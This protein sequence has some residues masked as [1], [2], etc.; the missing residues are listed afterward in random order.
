MQVM[1]ERRWVLLAVFCSGVLLWGEVRPALADAPTADAD[2]SADQQHVEDNAWRHLKS[3]ADHLRSAGRKELAENL[4]AEAEKLRLQQ[5]LAKKLTEL[6]ALREDVER[7]QA[8][9]GIGQVVTLRMQVVEC[10]LNDD[11]T[12]GQE[13]LKRLRNGRTNAAG[14]NDDVPYCCLDSSAEFA[15]VLDELKEHGSAKVLAEPHLATLSGRPAS[16]HTGGLQP[17][18]VP[19]SRGNSA[20]EFCEMGTR[21]DAVPTVHPDGT[22]HLKL[23]LRV[24]ETDAQKK[25][26]IGE[27]SIPQMRSWQLDTALAMKVGQTA[28]LVTGASSDEADADDAVENHKIMLLTV[29]PKFGDA[30]K[31]ARQPDDESTPETR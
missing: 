19:N 28:V 1:V 23:A 16:L 11:A 18:V 25:S 8:D 12:N 4:Q 9:L 7:L 29:T 10:Q 17:I 21:V 26:K 5:T 2:K 20:V 13:L 6:A 30:V 14:S 3:A 22:V 27:H 24:R 31:Q 15:R